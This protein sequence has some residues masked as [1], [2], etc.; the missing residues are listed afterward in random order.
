MKYFIISLIILKKPT[1]SDPRT[2]NTTRISDLV[3]KYL[4]MLHINQA[5]VIVLPFLCHEIKK[6]R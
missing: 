4:H 3:L 1:F 6:I 2:Y 5:L